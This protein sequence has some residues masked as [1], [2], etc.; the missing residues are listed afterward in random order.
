MAWTSFLY[1]ACTHCPKHDPAAI[2]WLI[3]LISER[4][5]QTIIA[6]GDIFD[7]ECVSDY[8]KVNAPK[9]SEEYRSV[10]EML[11]R[12]N[13]AAPK[14]NKVLV[15]GNHDERIF[16]VGSQHIS[17][18]IDYR[19]H[20][21]AL[22]HWKRFPY[23]FHQRNAFWLGQVVFWHGWSF[24]RT[25]SAELRRE[26]IDMVQGVSYTLAVTGHTHRPVRVQ[27]METGGVAYPFWRANS[28]C[29]VDFAKMKEGYVKC[30]NDSQWMHGVVVGACNTKR[31]ADTKRNWEAETILRPGGG[32]WD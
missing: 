2:D 7:A 31:R 4:Q 3:S 8:P 30:R 17:D 28:G 27:Q 18:L 13:A 21:K 15:E 16:R 1:F 10:N 23:E 20:V 14:A 11:E 29:L 26:I 22:K 32:A 5:P 6:G 24:P 9:L 19:K 25:L 12:I